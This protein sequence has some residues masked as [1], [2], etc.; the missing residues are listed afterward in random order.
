MKT[1]I[2][3]VKDLPRKVSHSSWALICVSAWLVVLIYLTRIELQAQTNVLN[4]STIFCDVMP[5]TTWDQKVQNCISALPKRGGIADATRIVGNQTSMKTIK[6]DRPIELRIGIARIRSS[7]SPFMLIQSPSRIS[8]VIA[9][10]WVNSGLA[11]AIHATTIENTSKDANLLEVVPPGGRGNGV[12]GVVI[13]DLA[14]VGNRDVPGATAGD[15]IVLGPAAQIDDQ[16]IRNVSVNRVFVQGFRGNGVTIDGNVFLSTFSELHSTHNAGD[17][18]HTRGVGAGTLILIQPTLEFCDDGLE[19]ESGA[20][21]TDINIIGGSISANNNGLSI[22]SG[23]VRASDVTFEN[24]L[25]RQIY[26]DGSGSFLLNHNTIAH[27]AAIGVEVAPATH[28]GQTPII[29]E[30]VF[31]GPGTSIL[32]GAMNNPVIIEKQSLVTG[33]IVDNSRNAYRYDL[34]DAVD[35]RLLLPTGRVLGWPDANFYRTEPGAIGITGDFHV[36][37][38]GRAFIAGNIYL[39]ESVVLLR[40]YPTATGDA[41]LLPDATNFAGKLRVNKTGSS[42][43]TLMFSQSWDHAPAC[44]ATNETTPTV[45][46]AASTRTQLS[47][48][49]VTNSNDVLSYMC[50]GY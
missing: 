15:G 28:F 25:K 50:L 2:Q 5:G 9:G 33:P 14:L 43:I 45:V 1:L 24:N 17:C 32:I 26:A 34:W 10:G 46:R 18:F 7:A 13:E 38:S 41:T 11:S 29:G 36:N 12:S 48:I 40:G 20:N 42:T 16:F 31:H 23:F 27:G 30:S 44:T 4:G 21:V 37:G 49:G 35:G 22:G 6:I 39:N 8:G 19:I 3:N 47:I